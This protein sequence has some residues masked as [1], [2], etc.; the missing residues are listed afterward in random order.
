[1]PIPLVRESGRWRFDTAVGAEELV[2]RR[3]GSNELRTIGLARE[4]ILAQE[5]FRDR[6][7]DNDG[8]LD[9][10]TKILSTPGQ[11]DGLYWPPAEGLPASPLDEYVET[12]RDYLEMVEAVS[13]IRG[14]QARLLTAQGPSAEG[15][16]RD[17]LEDGRLK[18]GWA[19]IAWP[20]EY[21]STGIKTFLV[22]HH[23]VVYEHDFGEQT[24]EAVAAI[25]V[26]DPGTEWIPV[27]LDEW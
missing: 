23:G 25:A 24:P 4:L 22:S 26:F 2:N 14:Y 11:Y 9:Y 1:M 16:A 10:A 20:V 21:G 13:P 18:N 15:G 3:I 12:D 7:W 27:D 17:Y 8:H 5:L 19:L 6:D